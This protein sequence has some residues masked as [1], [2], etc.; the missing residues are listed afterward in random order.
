MKGFAFE[1]MT[2]GRAVVLGD[3]GPWMCSGMTGG[4][5]YFRIDESVGLTTDALS[6]RLA[7]NSSVKIFPVDET[8]EENLRYLIGEYVSELEKANQFENADRVASLIDNYKSN[9][10]KGIPFRQAA[11]KVVSLPSADE[12]VVK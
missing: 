6:R 11:Q 7:K 1:Y 4:V 8:D 3:P 5:I 12:V 2:S 10:V 9:F